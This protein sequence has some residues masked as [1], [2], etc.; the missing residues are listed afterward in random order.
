MTV[1]LPEELEQYVRMQV[2]SGFFASEEEVISAAVR[3]LRQKEA[4]D[5]ERSVDASKASATKDA[6]EPAWKRVLDIMNRVPD[7]DY[8]RIPSDGSEQLDHYIYGGS[9]RT[10]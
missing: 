7:K 4:S 6:R 10:N 9:K 3:L 1:H 2:Q 8:D 5:S